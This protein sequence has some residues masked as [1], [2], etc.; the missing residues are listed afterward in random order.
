[1]HNTKTTRCS[2]PRVVTLG[3]IVLVAGM[4][5]GCEDW[6]D[7][8]NP[9]ELESPTLEDPIYVGL[10]ADGVVGDFQPAFAWT[11]LFSGAFTD[12][13]R[14]HHGFFE[15]GDIDRRDV[16][17]INGTYIAAVYNGLHRARFLAD[18]V[19]SRITVLL[20]DSASRSLALGRV[21][22]YGGY[23]YTLL[24]E[25][26]C[27]TPLERS[28]AVG[29]DEL[30]GM[31]VER[32]DEAIA[33]ATAAG[34]AADAALAA[35]DDELEQETFAA[36]AAGADSIANFARVGA[37]RTSL[38]LGDGDAAIAYA[39]AVTPAY[40]SDASPGFVFHADY[41]EGASF[42]DNRRTGNPF[43]E[44][45]ASDAEV[46]FSVSDRKSVV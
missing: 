26:M 12:E 28:A 22:A 13:L 36:I 6:L 17:N 27:S 7:V 4:L 8:T 24:G 30:F 40:A 20:A 33:V 5:A 25:Q 19:A 14:N 39:A 9:G 10:M 45:L 38:N 42:S 18:S 15:N 32:F 46:W 43:G 1:M 3:A 44:F 29:S 21:L 16:E 31:A 34:D 23:S 37:A 2:R 41:L 35:T 11:A